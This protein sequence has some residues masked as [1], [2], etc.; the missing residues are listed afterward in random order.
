MP[1]SFPVQRDNVLYLTEGGQETEIMYKFGHDLP[2]FAMYPLLDNPAAMADLRGMY[3]RVLDA[4][5][6]HGFAVMLTGLDYRASPDWGEKLG[7]SRET[8]ADALLQSIAFLR[9]VAQPYQEQI[10]EI[11]I[12][13]MAGPRGD[14]Y[15]LNR[16]ITADEAEEYH[17][18]QMET[19]NRADIDFISAVTFNNIPE[20]VGV[21]RAAARAGLPLCI[22]F[23]L[24]SDHRLKSGA[25]LKEAIEAVDAE[26]GEA[27]PACYGINCSHPL[28]F[29]PALEAGDWMLRVRSLR[30]NASAKEKIELCQIGH[31]EDG[32]PQDLGARM[33]DLARRYPHIDIWG[34]C[35]GTWDSHLNEIARHVR[36]A[37]T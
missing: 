24:S 30:P 35:C 8:L 27:R 23:T 31:L 20:A 32:D 2:E 36:A 25:S 6:Q 5:A 28:E 22:S 12:G 33:G 13:G 3:Q 14:A 9:E 37:R 10:S 4:A 1:A 34:G 7:Y 11:L 15:S 16:T 26:A 17:S 21:A 18:F 19:L 29:E